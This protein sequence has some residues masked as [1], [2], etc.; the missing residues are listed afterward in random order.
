MKPPSCGSC[1]FASRK[2]SDPRRRGQRWRCVSE[3]GRLGGAFASAFL[4]L[5][6]CGQRVHEVDDVVRPLGRTLRHDGL[7]G[8]LALDE[9]HELF[10]IGVLEA[11]G[12][13]GLGHAVDEPLRHVQLGLGHVGV[14]HGLG[15]VLHLAG[16]VQGDHD[17]VVAVRHDGDGRFGVPQ[18]RGADGHLVL[19]QHG[20]AQQFER[21]LAAGLGD[22]LVGLLEEDGR[23][24]VGVRELD[25]LH[26]AVGFGLDGFQLLVG[27]HHVLA[28]FV[29]VALHDVVGAQLAL[30]VGARLHV[31]HALHAVLRQLVEPHGV[32]LRGGEQLDG[33]V[34]EPERDGSFS[35]CHG[36]SFRSGRPAYDARLPRG[37][38][39]AGRIRS[40]EVP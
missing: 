12:V 4:L 15:D 29:L 1:R 11:G 35:A 8:Y 14:L 2:V 25:D 28:L 16:V 7:A 32:V 10:L 31:A 20:L 5:Q 37:D 3:R 18:H 22:Y 13:E 33:Y 30:A 36:S 40:E 21:A 27:H 19:G 26:G 24:L 17:Q 38:A 9:V 23:Y 39:A 34:H 6:A